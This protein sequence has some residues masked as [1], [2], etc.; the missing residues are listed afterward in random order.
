MSVSIVKIKSVFGKIGPLLVAS[1][2][3]T[4]VLAQTAA[5]SQ[6][7]K[8]LLARG[9]RQHPSVLQ[10]RSKIGEAQSELGV[11]EWSRYPAFSTEVRTAAVTSQNVARVEQPLWTGGRIS[12]QI[13]SAQVGVEVARAAL[14]EAEFNL[15]SQVGTLFFEVLRLEARLAGAKANVSEH[16]ELQEMIGRRVSAQISP[17]A[18]LVLAK[19]R[20]QQAISERLQI[21]RQLD[22]SRLN[23][24][25]WSAGDVATLHLPRLL[26]FRQDRS[27]SQWLE[28]AMAH[29]AQLRRLQLQVTAAET[30]VQLAQ[31]R[32]MPNLVAGVQHGWGGQIAKTQDRA[33]LSFQFQPGAGFSALDAVRTAVAR[34]ETARHEQEVFASTLDVQLRTAYSELLV[35]EAQIPPAQALF[36]QSDLVLES[37][38]RQYQIGRK[39]WLDV[40]NA[41]REKVQAVYGLADAR[42]GY[43]LAQLRL[44]LLAGDIDV[45]QMDAI[46]D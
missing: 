31:S 42:Y 18:D 26:H 29:S 16:R 36:E 21:Q 3:S 7:L 37:Y 34:K 13:N 25:Q 14:S 28:Q 23:L 2:I 22:A 8:D 9:L 6:G 15:M 1:L 38:L 32:G 19:A 27:I 46:N 20:T 12:A 39:N 43:Q 45:A 40:L 33:Y 41:Q 30:Q 17:P 11:A 35:L 4:P 5:D 10:A 24:S 44:M